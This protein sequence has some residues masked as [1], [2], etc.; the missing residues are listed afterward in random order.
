MM[1]TVLSI[2]R[3]NDP[4]IATEKN[5]PLTTSLVEHALAMNLRDKIE[6]ILPSGIDPF[7][8]SSPVRISPVSSEESKTVKRKTTT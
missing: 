2:H 8:H 6:T 5:K 3:L 1:S 4:S 7:D